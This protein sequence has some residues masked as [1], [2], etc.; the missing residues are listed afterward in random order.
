MLFIPYTEP[1]PLI[2]C[3]CRTPRVLPLQYTMEYYSTNNMQQT[4]SLH[5][6]T[7]TFRSHVP[8]FAS[9]QEAAPTDPSRYQ[10]FVCI[11]IVCNMS[12]TQF[13]SAFHSF[14]DLGQRVIRVTTGGPVS[15]QSYIVNRKETLLSFAWYYFSFTMLVLFIPN[16]TTYYILY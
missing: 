9:L 6:A 10:F 11:H 4:Y 16:T 7:S 3:R 2:H 12:L 5:K 13:I 8:V 15:T 1:C 14:I